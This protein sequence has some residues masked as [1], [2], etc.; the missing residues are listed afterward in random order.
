VS[1]TEDGGATWR[2]TTPPT[3]IPELY[4]NDTTALDVAMLDDQKRILVA[5]TNGCGV[6]HSL[7]QGRTWST[8]GRED[9]I[10][11]DNAPQNVQSLAID[12]HSPDTLYV[13]SDSNRVF[14]SHDRGETWEPGA[15]TLTTNI[16][17]IDIDPQIPER[18]YLLA[19]VNGFWRSD[20]SGRT[21]NSYSTGLE[22]K[23]LS[24]M[25]VIPDKAEVLFVGSWRGELWKTTNGG[26]HWQPVRHDPAVGDIATISS[27]GWKD[28]AWIG[29]AARGGGGIYNYQT[30]KQE[31][32]WRRR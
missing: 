31:W 20:D 25:L 26:E 6:L 9:C 21:W 22:D 30:G 3:Q 11:P 4:L 29:S 10:S 27:R 32:F 16:R 7:D 1:I 28:G 23:L 2:S 13:A 5:G 17:M 8:G 24:A 12:S 19:G 18:V 15:I 14:V